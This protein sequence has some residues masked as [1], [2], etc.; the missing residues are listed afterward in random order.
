MEGECSAEASPQGNPS[1]LGLPCRGNFTSVVPSS[2]LGGLRVYVCDSDPRPGVQVV[3]TDST[4]I[5]IRSLMLKK[6]KEQE[7]QDK[8]K[9]ADAPKKKRAAADKPESSKSS[10]KKKVD[11]ASGSA[12]YE[13]YTVEMLRTALKEKGLPVKGRKSDLI[14]RLKKAS[15]G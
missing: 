3:K 6:P 10:K 8:A 15:S 14:T 4:N 9:Q 2:S 11:T 12:S 13:G 1:L 7:A 5:L